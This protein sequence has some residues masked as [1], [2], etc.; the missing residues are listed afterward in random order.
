LPNRVFL[1][2]ADGKLLAEIE[3]DADGKAWLSPAPSQVTILVD[4]ESALFTFTGVVDGDVLTLSGGAGPTTQN[5]LLGTYLVQLPGA[6]SGATQYSARVGGCYDDPVVDDPMIVLPARVESLC[7]F[8]KGNAVIATAFDTTSALAFAWKSGL[9][10]SGPNGFTDVALG[11]WA[12]AVRT[13]FGRKPLLA[14]GLVADVAFL[15]A[16]V[17]TEPI[18]LTTLQLSEAEA[19]VDV[20]PG[21]VFRTALTVAPEPNASI[22]RDS[23]VTFVMK[24]VASG[25]FVVDP[26]EALPRITSSSLVADEDGRF[27]VRWSP[28]GSLAGADGG[29]V[30][31]SLAGGAAPRGSWTFVVPPGAT[32]LRTPQLS[33]N[34]FRYSG[35]P[36]GV[37]GAIF[38]DSDAV[39][40]FKQFR[41]TPTPPDGLGAFRRLLPE[42]AGL[43][44]RTVTR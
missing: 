24:N 32:E 5:V 1:N 28:A 19:V 18:L 29:L 35:T 16:L 2:D 13:T 9:S 30:G 12:P 22:Y 14:G 4:G 40:G 34:A 8:N 33:S 43:R 26:A 31:L 44:W 6:V 11:P 21:L 3:T 41:T 36:I 20:P 42:Q 25:P 39:D 17:G 38:L 15:Y 27:S 7:V 37:P 23:N 10:L